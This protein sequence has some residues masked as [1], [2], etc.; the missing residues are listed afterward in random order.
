ML[1]RRLLGVGEKLRQGVRK[2]PLWAKVSHQCTQG[3]ETLLKSV[4]ASPSNGSHGVEHH[5][6][7]VD[8]LRHAEE[9]ESSSHLM[10][11][12]ASAHDDAILLSTT[13]EKAFDYLDIVPDDPSIC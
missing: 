6:S 7:V 4:V 9:A 8:V 13:L 11:T 1:T 10:R 3:K 5:T 12:L 2:R